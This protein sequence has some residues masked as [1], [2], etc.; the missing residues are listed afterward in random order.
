[1]LTKCSFRRKD[2]AKREVMTLSSFK[3]FLIF[4][5]ILS[6]K[7]FG[8]LCIACLLLIITLRFTCSEMKM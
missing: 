6:L 3:I 7:S 8:K 1:M 5:N 4:S 2:R